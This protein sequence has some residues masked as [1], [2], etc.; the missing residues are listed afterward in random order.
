MRVRVSEREKM[1]E[2]ERGIV[3]CARE[4]KGKRE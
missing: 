2:K 1:R 4:R 3:I